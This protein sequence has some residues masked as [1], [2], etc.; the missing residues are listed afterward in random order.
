MYLMFVAAMICSIFAGKFI[1]DI[2]IWLY[3]KVTSIIISIIRVVVHLIKL[4]IRK[5]VAVYKN[6]RDH[7]IRFTI[8]YVAVMNKKIK[9]QQTKIGMID[10]PEASDNNVVELISIEQKMKKIPYEFKD[11]PEFN[12]EIIEL[13][14][15]LKYYS[16]MLVA[17]SFF[18]N[19]EL[20][21]KLRKKVH[22]I[23]FF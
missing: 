20:K 17:N 5:T 9:Q 14:D 11:K 23:Q 8:K 3:Q 13:Y 7:C 1:L 2:S 15:I 19:F 18:N 16:G 6:V 22:E 21:G 10:E 12:E 4:L